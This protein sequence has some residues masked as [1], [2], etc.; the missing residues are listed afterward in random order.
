MPLPARFP[1]QHIQEDC[2][3][4]HPGLSRAGML[5]GCKLVNNYLTSTC[6]SVW[7][8][9]SSVQWVDYTWLVSALV[10]QVKSVAHVYGSQ[11]LC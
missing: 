10:T 11:I 7:W 8:V 9:R 1:Y 5:Q 6:T 2:A 4:S 3:G